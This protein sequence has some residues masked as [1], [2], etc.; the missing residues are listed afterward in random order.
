MITPAVGLL[1]LY[2][3]LY[4]RI[5]PARRA[6]VDACC[7][8]LAGALEARGLRV[9]RAPVCRLAPEVRAAVAGFEKAG[10]DAVVTVHLAY[11]PSLESAPVLARMRLPLIVLDTTPDYDFGPRQHPDRIMLNHGIHGVQDLCNLLLRLG[12]PFVL[13]AGHGRRSDVLQRV[14]SHARAA[15][16]AAAFGRARVGRIGKPFPGMG[17]FAVPPAALR[18]L[19]VTVIPDSGAAIRRALAV[20]PP[21]EIAAELAADR[22]RF[23][24][25]GLDAAAHRR[26]AG[27]GLAVRRWIAAERL[28][29]FTV[30][31]LDVRRRAGIPAVPF[32]EASK[33]M[34]RGVGYAGEGDV[35]TAAFV[36]ALMAG[37]PD[38]TFTEMF[39]PDWKGNTIFVSHMGEVNVKLLAGRP[40]LQEVAYKFSEADNPVKPVGRLRSG[41][42]VF[43]N[44]APAP[45][46]RFRLI[47]AP[48]SVPP[49]RG[50]DRMADTVH[51]W[52]RPR[53]PLADFLAAYSRAG[54][55]HHAALVYG[56]EPAVLADMAGFLGW[57]TI[58]IP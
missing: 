5:L 20:L 23:D 33:A 6:A 27:V 31:F 48:V 29:A 9:R 1:P 52:F 10:V 21:A 39:C 45:G 37:Y 15:R 51:G 16:M 19:G 49:V 4:D 30:N 11:S 35:L 47:L 22:R 34:A 26:S 53:R 8:D 43:A 55:T 28:T 13:E 38:T 12:K 42:A 46:G 36:G 24:A 7:D 3:D 25:A 2:L 41:A 17:D 57:E 56:G 58:T 18:R 44:L 54:G 50:T 40:R 14:A 32:L